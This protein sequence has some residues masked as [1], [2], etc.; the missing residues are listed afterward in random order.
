[1]SGRNVMLNL[2]SRVVSILPTAAKDV[3]LVQTTS[4]LVLW[5]LERDEKEATLDIIELSFNSHLV[6][7]HS[8]H[9]G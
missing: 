5:Y 6:P 1:M 4:H 8:K 9:E 7:F 2:N 3:F